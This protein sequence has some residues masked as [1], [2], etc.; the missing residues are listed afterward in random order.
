MSYYLVRIGE[1]SKYISEAKSQGFIAIGWEEVPDLQVL[2]NLDNI[3]KAL[4]KSSYGYTP[5]QIA[6]QAGQIYRFGIEMQ[7]GDT[8]FSPLGKGGYLVG[9]AGEYYFEDLP[10]G[11]CPFKHRR[12]INWKKDSV[13]KEDMS[14]NLAYSLGATLTIFSL[15]KYEKELEQLLLGQAFTPAEKPQRIRDV[16]LSGLM[17]LDG[18]EFE[19]FVRHVLEVIGFSAETTQYVGD[20]GIDVNGILD[21]EGLASIT[22]RVQ[23]KRVRGTIGNKDVL[24]LRGALSQ[25]EHGCLITLSTF[26]S[27]AIEEAEATGKINIKLIDG[28]D[29]AGIILKH[30][31]ELD[32]KYKNT[33][34]IRRKKDFNIEDQFEIAASK[35]ALPEI[36]EP[37]IQDIDIRWD[38][39]VC[40][41]KEDGFKRAF[42]KQ[43]AW[44][45]VRINK[46]Y[47]PK[48]RYIAMY[49]TAPISK[50]TYYGKVS[51]IEPYQGT[52]KYIVHLDG[53]PIKLKKAIGLG[54]NPHLKPQSPKYAK[55]DNILNAKT[56]DDVWR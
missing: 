20:K 31:D 33:F 26:T 17:E 32:N 49:Q 13:L 14:T 3:K 51:K 36:Q 34:G 54:K 30:F 44:W 38:T 46:K 12:K 25:S 21:A 2:K 9:T 28:N 10:K 22:L 40:A 43:K 53:M 50:I 11:G 35:E 5:G 18:K 19:E 23:V 16:I 52:N 48:I 56:L 42:I 45:A 8:V 41:A 1:G 24:A 6:I 55:L 7:E 37:I 47:I 4:T 27:Q 15:N 39:I 29:L